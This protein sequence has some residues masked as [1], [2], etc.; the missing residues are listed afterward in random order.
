MSVEIDLTEGGIGIS[1]V[2]GDG[3]VH[4][5]QG[6]GAPG[7][8]ASFQDAAPLGSFYRD[9]TAGD[10]YEK[11]VAGTGADKWR[12]MP[13]LTD[14]G[15]MNLKGCLRAATGEALSAGARDL[16]S[17]PFTDDDAPTMV[18][19]DFTVGDLVLGG[20]GGTP[21]L[22]E[23]TV[24]SAPSITLALK[25]PALVA[26]DMFIA[27][28]Y[29]PDAP[30]AQEASALVW[31]TGSAIE[32][33][34]DINWN[35]ADGINLTAGFTPVNGSVTSADTVNSAIEK[36]VAN[37]DDL[38]TLTGVAQGAVDLGTFTGNTI[39]DNV[40]IKPALQSLETAV[41]LL[42]SRVET[43]PTQGGGQISHDTVI[44]DDVLAVE[45]ELW[46]QEIGTQNTRILEVEAFHDG[47]AS[48]DAS[49]VKHTVRD[50][51]L[52]GSSFNFE[53]DV[54]LNG[55]AGAQEMRLRVTTSIVGGVRVISQRRGINNA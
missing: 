52:I 47:N 7:G 19:A 30:D 11:N 26:G 10:S 50:K 1:D 48:N 2:N 20:V 39:P 32:K 45:W 29:L 34:G 40:A 21:I 5:L 14:I 8:D 37:Q 3:Q 35:L 42:D 6:A 33:L 38:I 54:D 4:I 13:N 44:A 49:A 27:K 15:N 41:E 22:Y 17:S 31:Y 36:L 25:S 46:V 51:K 28:N 12:R 16:V 9:R 24:V 55:A 23:V 43:S 53:L 18:A